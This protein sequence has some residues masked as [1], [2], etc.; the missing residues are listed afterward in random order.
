MLE[1]LDYTIR[2]GS[3]PTFIYFDLY[4][5]STYAAH[6]LYI[7]LSDIAVYMQ[8]SQSG[9]Q[10]NQRSLKYINYE[11]HAFL[12]KSAYFVFCLLPTVVSVSRAM[13]ISI[14]WKSIINM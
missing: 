13:A 14:V 10:K 7:P 3:T 2:T 8:L 12:F 6:N 5:Y 9:K 1:T 11:K 4:L